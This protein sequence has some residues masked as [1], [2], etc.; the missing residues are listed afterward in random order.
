MSFPFLLFGLNMVFK[1]W[2]NEHHK[3]NK[4]N[5]ENV[6]HTK[7]KSSPLSKRF[8]FFSTHLLNTWNLKFNQHLM[9]TYYF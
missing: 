2:E 3:A 7:Y 4:T 5:E 8:P 9:K 6:L 1:D